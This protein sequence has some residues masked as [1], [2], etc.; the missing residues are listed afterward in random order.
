MQTVR[1]SESFENV[2]EKTLIL[3]ETLHEIEVALLKRGSYTGHVRHST[4]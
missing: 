4:G 3:D 1:H 2:N